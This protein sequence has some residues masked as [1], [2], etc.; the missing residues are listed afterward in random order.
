[1]LVYACNT[2][3]RFAWV[4]RKRNV[5]LPQ[6][7]HTVVTSASRIGGKSREFFVSDSQPAIQVRAVIWNNEAQI[8]GPRLS[9]LPLRSRWGLLHLFDNCDLTIDSPANE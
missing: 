6:L 3:S 8:H 1:L 5:F 2:I 4:N 7:M 9:T